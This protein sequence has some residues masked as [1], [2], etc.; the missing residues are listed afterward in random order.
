MAFTVIQMAKPS[1]IGDHENHGLIIYPVPSAGLI[2]I[3]NDIPI[4]EITVSDS[5]G[6]VIFRQ[7]PGSVKVIID[8]SEQGEGIY[9]IRIIIP[10]GVSV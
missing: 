5:E 3:E 4:E 7:K 1:G 2:N 6:K 8:L 9:F 10:E